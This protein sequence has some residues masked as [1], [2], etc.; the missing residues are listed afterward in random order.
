MVHFMVN[1]TLV[2]CCLVTVTAWGS[3]APVF[4]LQRLFNDHQPPHLPSTI[5]FVDPL[6]DYGQTTAVREICEE[7]G[8]RIVE[9]WSPQVSRKIL[10]QQDDD[11]SLVINGEVIDPAAIVT[12]T[13]PV[14]PTP[15]YLSS[16]SPPESQSEQGSQSASESASESSETEAE[17]EAEAAA[18]A[19]AAEAEAT[20]VARAWL[21][22]HGVALT[23]VLGVVCESDVGL[24]TAE[25][26]SSAL[27]LPTANGRCEARRDKYLQQEA[28]GRVLRE[29][30]VRSTEG[31][32][33]RQVLTDD[34]AT[35]EA[36]V[37]ELH[38]ISCHGRRGQ[39]S[40][41]SHSDSSS[42]SHSG[43]NSDNSSS[44]S[45]DRDSDGDST[46]ASHEDSMQC[47]IKPCRGSASLGVFHATSLAHAARLFNDSVGR[48]GSGVANLTRSAALLVQEVP[49]V[50]FSS[51]FPFLHPSIPPSSHPSIPSSHAHNLNPQPSTL[52]P[53]PSTLNPQP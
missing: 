11:G 15:P 47:V 7:L 40:S 13:A 44:N 36:F 24:K 22:S 35:A 21:T 31:R 8:L 51:L 10:A 50:S 2:W 25:E 33:V 45:S 46:T 30:G 41:N 32:V 34:W 6:D 53:P 48:Y 16:Q 39:G 18:E 17:A 19:A 4:S 42:S 20:A 14:L 1:F 26:F 49:F 9:M 23:D 28:V 12:S 43:S 5:V 29:R 52:N 37:R 27:R 38:G 3:L